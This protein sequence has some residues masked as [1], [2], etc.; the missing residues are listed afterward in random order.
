VEVRYTDLKEVTT[1]RV[2]WPI[3]LGFFEHI[4]MVVVWCEMRQAFRHLRADR[5]ISWTPLENRYPKRRAVLLKAWKTERDEEHARY[6]AE[7]PARKAALM[8]PTVQ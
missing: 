6:E 1:D 5:I 4:R 3:A 2:V 7:L 8:S